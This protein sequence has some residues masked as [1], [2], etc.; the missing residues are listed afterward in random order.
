MG[1]GLVAH[2]GEEGS[3]GTSLDGRTPGAGTV[4]PPT[5]VVCAVTLTTASFFAWAVKPSTPG[6]CFTWHHG[7]YFL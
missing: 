5:R 3:P 4:P 2:P 6:T 1:G 7:V